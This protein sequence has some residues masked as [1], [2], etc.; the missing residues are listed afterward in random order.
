MRTGRLSARPEARKVLDGHLDG[1]PGYSTCRSNPDELLEKHTARRDRRMVRKS[2][3][4]S[5]LSPRV[6]HDV[7]RYYDRARDH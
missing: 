6:G 1:R 5:R 7:T 2:A 4:S 3:G